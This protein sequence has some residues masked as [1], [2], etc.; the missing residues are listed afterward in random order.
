MAQKV[1]K[2]RNPDFSF[3]MT[4]PSGWIWKATGAGKRWR[5][6]PDER[7]GDRMVMTLTSELPEGSA[8]WSQVVS[9]LPGKF[10]R[11]EANVTCDLA[12]GERGGGIA[13]SVQP[14]TD[15]RPSGERRFTP[16][17]RRASQPI[18]IRTY[19]E[20]PAGV[21]GLKV[22]V[23]L[24]EATGTARIHHVRFIR[25]LEP[26]EESHILAIP[27]PSPALPPPRVVEQ[28]CVCSVE[29]QE[30]PIT[31]RLAECFG[32]KRVHP[33]FPAQFSAKR[34]GADALLLPDPSP[35]SSIRSL[36]GL[37]RLSAE[38]IV[39]ISLPA[40]AKLAGDALKL[41]LIEQ[42][43]DPIHACV[44]FSNYATRG[45]ALN[46]VFAYAW[47]NVET[48]KRQNVETQEPN[49]D[50]KGAAKRK[51]AETWNGQFVQHQFRK[52]KALTEFCKRHGF[53]TLLE[54]MCD[55]DST[56]DQPICLHKDGPRG[57]LFVLDIEPGEAESS[58]FGE[59]VPAMHLLLSILGRTQPS[60][61]QYVAP[62]RKE[63][64]FRSLVREMAVRFEPAVVY[65]E[66]VPTEEV[67]GQLVI[68]GRSDSSYALPLA[69][70]PVILVRSGLTAGDA[71]SAC[72]AALWFKQLLRAE[73]YACPY[74]SRLGGQFRLAWVP[75]AAQWEAGDGWRR[76]GRPPQVPTTIEA[77]GGDLAAL[78]DVVTSTAHKARVVVPAAD[79]LY[80]HLEAW[81][82]RLFSTFVPGR[83]F[84]FRP[85]DGIAFDDRDVFAWSHGSPEVQVAV[86]PEPFKDDEYRDILPAARQVVRIEVPG[87]QADFVANSIQRTDFLVTLLEQVIGLVFGLIAV[88][89]QPGVVHFDHF[90]PVGPGEDLTID[91]RDPMLH[92]G[93]SRVG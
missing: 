90:P 28:I 29:A 20:A 47:R 92:S 79:G 67:A 31:R 86:D 58:T 4:G 7:F 2:I 8:Y 55:R 11:V 40:F 42:E 48:S 85:A 75:C 78:I 74:A 80:P 35:P 32:S 61:G 51:N 34:L 82:P 73:P 5:R 14:D 33:L 91:R 59:P 52:T 10:Y 25:I 66:D 26:D 63:S 65:D 18:D 87:G 62:V 89:R 30:R 13:L 9:C 1:N 37:M 70:K 6:G 68:I 76:S 93:A 45:F 77:E 69:P 38:R 17:L 22:S 53:V 21:R 16:A 56:S 43:D 54:S 41:R 24:A 57:G 72:A 83:H 3:G 81:L 44:A 23:G 12:A 39:V 15:G 49:R 84:T 64:E 50:H 60:L 71:E 88:N 46:D 36:A 19:Y 27:P